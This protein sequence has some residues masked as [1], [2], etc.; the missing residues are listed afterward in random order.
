MTAPGFN[1]KVAKRKNEKRSKSISEIKKKSKKKY[2]NNSTVKANN[3][4]KQ[5]SKQPKKRSKPLDQQTKKRNKHDKP[6]DNMVWVR[7]GKTQHPAFILSHEND[8]TRVKYS[9]NGLTD[10]VPTS[11]IEY[12]DTSKRSRRCKSQFRNNGVQDQEN[13]PA[14]EYSC[15]RF[16]ETSAD[17]DVDE[18]EDEDWGMDTPSNKKKARL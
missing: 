14:S 6:S 1:V 18:S 9:S 15:A 13:H 4:N 10:L 7:I 12:D 17:D 2:D 8:K 11:S 16:M 5:L 3:S